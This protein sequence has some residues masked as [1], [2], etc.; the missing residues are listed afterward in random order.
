MSFLRPYDG[1]YT[2]WFA[3]GSGG[4]RG[5]CDRG[6]RWPGG[7]PP[8]L[9]LW[10]L[11]LPEEAGTGFTPHRAAN[12][13]SDLS[14]SG[15]P[16]AVT[17]RVAAVSGPI[18][19]RSTQLDKIKNLHAEVQHSAL[20][21]QRHNSVQPESTEGYR[22]GVRELHG[23]GTGSYAEGIPTTKAAQPPNRAFQPAH[24]QYLCRARRGVGR[25]EALDRPDIDQCHSSGGLRDPFSHHGD[26]P[27]S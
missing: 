12:A 27:L 17:R 7:R 13:A 11:V 25:F 14:R 16:P 1:P 22:K 24:F 8:R 26:P 5:R 19:K 2:P 20:T 10:R 6:Q 3:H 15:L 18:P 9:S 4:A 23:R 21:G